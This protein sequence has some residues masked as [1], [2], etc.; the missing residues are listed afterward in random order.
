MTTT[1]ATP[2]A[3]I[4]ALDLGK[5]KTVACLYDPDTAAARY[6]T[7]TTSRAELARLIRRHRPGRVVIEACALAGWVSDLCAELGAPC[8]VANTASEAWKFKHAKRKTD[9]DDSLRLAQSPGAARRCCG[10][11]WSNAPG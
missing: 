1:T 10:S 6:E 2:T 8:K 3:A 4:L 11:C 7:I 9:R 5:Y